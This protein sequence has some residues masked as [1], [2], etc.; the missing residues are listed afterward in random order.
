[1]SIFGLL[2]R[3]RRDADMRVAW[4]ATLLQTIRSH[5][6][7]IR[8]NTNQFPRASLGIPHA[9]S[10]F[11]SPRLRTIDRIG[12]SHSPEFARVTGPCRSAS[13]SIFCVRVDSGGG[14][15]SPLLLDK[16]Q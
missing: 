5:S 8:W 13:E 2:I 15:R 3:Q 4:L 14:Q 9:I 6:G 12:R 10:N 1:M 16:F 11:A 7:E